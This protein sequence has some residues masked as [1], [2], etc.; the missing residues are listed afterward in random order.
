LHL[1]T[2]LAKYLLWSQHRISAV[3]IG[4]GVRIVGV[5]AEFAAIVAVAV[6]KFRCIGGIGVG[7]G[8]VAELATVLA[9]R[10]FQPVCF[11][12]TAGTVG[13]VYTLIFLVE[14]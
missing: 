5:G 11:I 3:R 2:N 7:P 1:E 13:V 14:V 10:I 6:E 12:R 9:V 4:C 8:F